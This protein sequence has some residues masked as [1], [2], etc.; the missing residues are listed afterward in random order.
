MVQNY[1]QKIIM[2]S[3][4]K[5]ISRISLHI[6]STEIKAEILTKKMDLDF[7]VSYSRAMV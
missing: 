4:K 7:V 2:T 5:R 1:K 6:V 3:Q